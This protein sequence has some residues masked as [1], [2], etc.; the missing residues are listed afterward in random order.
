MEQIEIVELLPGPAPKFRFYL[1]TAVLHVDGGLAFGG[2]EWHE[3]YVAKLTI[4]EKGQRQLLESLM[5]ARQDFGRGTI[6]ETGGGPRL[7]VGNA[8]VF[9]AM[10]EIRP[11]TAKELLEQKILPLLNFAADTEV[12]A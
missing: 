9:I 12:A 11:T 2:F 1:L 4:H 10:A 5:K 7:K 8:M 6:I 3:K